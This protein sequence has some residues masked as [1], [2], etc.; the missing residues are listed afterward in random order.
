MISMTGY[1]QSSVTGK[2][3]TISIEL[4]SVN[5]RFLEISS[6][7]PRE[8]QFRENDI[9]ELIRSKVSRAKINLFLGIEQ[10]SKAK[11]LLINT[12]AL[13][14]YKDALEEIRKIAKIKETVSLADILRFSNE[15]MTPAEDDVI[16]NWDLISK[17]IS[18]AVNNL[19]QMRR[20]EGYEL[21]RDISNRIR[22]IES[23]LEKVVGLSNNLLP[24]EREKLR[25]RVAQLFEN[26]EID[27]Q[28]L[29]LEIV[30]LADKLDVTE[31]CVRYRSHSKFFLEAMNGQEPAGRRLNFLLQEMGREVTTIGSKCN[32]A[33]IAQLVVKIKEELEKI[34][35]QV[36]NIE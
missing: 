16:D 14:S 12:E 32:N 20:K 30:L 13:K 31:E 22:E 7:L 28:R 3:V 2:G 27:E 10:S 5:S 29:Q 11:K 21:G 9:K 23:I 35:E 33:E 24:T 19:N 34:R 6:K 4:R 26:D 18:N 15:I 25:L 36:Q 8:L 1:G 17:A